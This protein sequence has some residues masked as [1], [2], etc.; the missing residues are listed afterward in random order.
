MLETVGIAID[1]DLLDAWR[2]RVARMRDALGWPPAALVARVHRRDASLALAAPLDQLLTATEVNEWAWLAALVDCGHAP[3][4]LQAPGYPAPWDEDSARQT[5]RALARAERKPALL[6]LVGAAE[7][8]GLTVLID[9]DSVSLGIGRGAR[10]WP[11]AAQPAPGEVD[12]WVLGDAPV[13]LVTGSNG[14]TTTTRLLAACVRARGWRTAYTCTD[15]VYVG[16]AQR[17]AGDYSGPAGARAALRAPDIEAAI[18]ETARGGLLRRGLAVQHVH[19]AVVTNISDDHFG[20][21]GVHDLDDLAE[22]KLSIAR[23]LGPQGILVLNADDALLVRHAAGLQARRAWFALDADA[24]LLATQR[25]RGEATCGVRAGRLRLQQAQADHDLGPI[26]GMPL[27]FGGAARYNIANLAAAALAAQA[28]G[29]GAPVIGEVFARFGSD[30]AD[31]PGRLQHW[32]L[33][34]AQI[35]VDYAHNP[36]GLHG[37]LEVAT[38]DRQG[39]LGLLLGQ[40]GNREDEEIRELARAA[41]AYRPDRIL[42]KDM[43]GMLRGRAIGEV[44]ALLRAELGRCG[45]VAAA[46]SDCLE[47]YQAVRELLAW[48]RPGDVLVLPVHGKAERPRVG[49]LLA[50]LEHQRWQPGQP[51]P[52]VDPAST[53]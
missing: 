20:E 24:P 14:K 32:S 49:A 17:A 26:T 27:A 11:Q 22:V 5:L 48:A 8:R 36:E 34:G 23:A 9:D 35:F 1:D 42:L 30:H 6:A 13:A 31:N 2:R 43:S 3:A 16:T 41:A 44:P 19:V 53:P 38:R 15:G 7:A 12:W 33:G 50:A 4:M 29:V 37:L 52:P 46:V 10:S 18:L 51:L 40:A 39:R 25:A 47:E 28:L 21:Y 45:L